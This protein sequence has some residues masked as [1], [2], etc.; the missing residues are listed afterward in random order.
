MSDQFVGEIRPVGFTFAPIG[1]ASCNGQLLSISQNTALFSLLGTQFGGNGTTTFALPN[2]QGNVALGMGQGPGLL[3]YSIG[4]TEGVATVT[5]I[6]VQLPAHNHPALAEGARANATLNTPVGNA[7]GKS[8]TGD[9]PYSGAVPNIKMSGS[10]TAPAGGGEPHNNMMP[11]L[12]INFV[13]AMV[14]IF[15]TRS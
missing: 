7:W 12:T 14:G 1:W 15:P 3:P 13:I 8:G 11:Y 9:T 10:A 4:E 6:E 2:L 5:L